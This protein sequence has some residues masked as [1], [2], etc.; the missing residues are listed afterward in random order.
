MRFVRKTDS[1]N[2]ITVPQQIMDALGGREIEFAIEFNG[3]TIKLKPHKI[4]CATC[5]KTIQ[6]NY[7][8]VFL[9]DSCLKGLRNV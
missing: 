2:R 9:C 8:T 5:G 3:D 1:R 4:H 7:R 6:N